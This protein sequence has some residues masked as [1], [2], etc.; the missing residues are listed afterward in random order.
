MM[1]LTSTAKITK[2]RGRSLRCFAIAFLLSNAGR[3]YSRPASPFSACNAEQSVSGTL[4]HQHAIVCEERRAQR[5]RG[6]NRRMAIDV[7]AAIDSFWQSAQRG[8]YF[9]PD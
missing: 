8:D 6:R 3:A 7:Q 2:I 5:H 4:P 9:P 1:I